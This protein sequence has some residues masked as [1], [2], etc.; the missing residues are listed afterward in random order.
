MMN[1]FS[2]SLVIL[3]L[4]TEFVAKHSLSIG[5]LFQ[6]YLP[7]VKTRRLNLFNQALY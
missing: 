4:F 2:F 1:I 3:H 6:V 7:L 5:N